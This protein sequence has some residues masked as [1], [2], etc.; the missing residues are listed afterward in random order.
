MDDEKIIKQL[1]KL[2]YNLWWT[3]NPFVK[4]FFKSID[5]ILWKE[6][7]ENPIR[8]LKESQLLREKFKD[9][10]FIAKLKYIHSVFKFYMNRHSRYEDI[11]KKPIVFLSPEYG[12]HHTLLIY[13]GGLGFLA[14]DILKESSDLEFPMVGVGF[15]YPQG[16]VRQRLRIDGWQED[17]EDS[18]GKEFMPARKILDDKGN[19][20]K[21]YVYVG[22]ERIYF[23][24]WKVEVGRI[25][26]YL[27]DTNVDENTPWNK[28]ISSRLYV[29]DKVLRLKQQIVLGFGTL[30]LLEKLGIDAGGFHI[31]EDYPS[32]I[33]LAKLLHL[34]KEGKSWNEAIETVRNMSLFTTHTPLLAAINTYPFHMIE[35]Q[36]SYVKELYGVDVNKILELGTN[37]QNPSEGFNSTIMSMRLSK[38]VNAVSKRHMETARK[39]WSFLFEKDEDNPIDYVTNGVHFPTWVSLRF[40]KLF[41][42][43]LGENFIE[44]HDVADLW[45]LVDDIPDEEIWRCH[46]ENKLKLFNHIK[47][48][49]RERWANEKADP[50]ILVAEGL[51]LD[52]DILTIGFARRMTAYKRP[53][54]IF[55]DV[56]R[57]KKIVTNS[58]RPVQIIFAGKAHPADLEGKSIIQRIFNYA[59]DPEFEGRIAF[60]EDYDELLAHYLVTGVD[61]WLNNPLP[62]LEACG[63]SG[64]KASMNGVLHFSILDGWWVEGY[65]GK[66]GWAFGNYKVE[67]DRNKADAEAIYNILENEIV[68]LYYNRDR[69]GLPRA[70]IKKMKEAIKSVTPNFCSRRMFKDYINKFYERI[71]R[72]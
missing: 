18:N 12:L 49:A 63:T 37:P 10:E 51:F 54:L 59:R 1:E 50:S 3:W 4:Q 47:E 61:V 5:P 22:K 25:P 45:Q 66:N 35:D 72:Q 56:E 71:L 57:L 65:N 29:P 6:T 17:L 53:D 11:Y 48:R 46:Y 27:L 32:F 42:K 20:L 13:A 36:F 31:N 40:R 69:E 24:V 16:Y 23:G 52:P 39:M 58:E 60:I 15:M 38:Y 62:P 43:Y 70:W 19:W 21:G 67:G 2:A 26:L 14:G 64:M 34:I 7:K 68:P 41:T 55:Y 8:L 30:I 9:E 33:L 44:L 28:E